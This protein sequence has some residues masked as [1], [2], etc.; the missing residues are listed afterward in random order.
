[1]GPYFCQKLPKKES[2]NLKIAPFK[3]E[4]TKNI[5]NKKLIKMLKM[6]MT[7]FKNDTNTKNVKFLKDISENSYT[8]DDCL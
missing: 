8:L 4:K 1:M 7:T 2:K 6:K 3:I 5:K